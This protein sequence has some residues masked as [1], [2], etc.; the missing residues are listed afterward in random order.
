MGALLSLPLLAVPSMGTLLTF[1]AS[2][3]GAATCGAVCSACGKCNNS[4][5]TR[6][7]YAFILL[8]NSLLSWVL[9][10]PW[11]V[12]KL[13]SVLLDYVTISCGGNECTGF[14]AVHRVNF[15]LGLFH[16]ALAFLLIGVNS[17][18]DKRAAVQNGFWQA[19]PENEGRVFQYLSSPGRTRRGRGSYAGGLGQQ[20]CWRHGSGDI[21]QVAQSP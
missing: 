4:I 5:A 8:I 11:A 12:K 16:F 21:Q 20:L 13:Q 1:G 2:C 14:A 18:K 10:T 7:A 3:C 15:A 17:S 9:L 6:I 19:S